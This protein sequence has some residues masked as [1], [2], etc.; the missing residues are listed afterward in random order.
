MKSQSLRWKSTILVPVPFSPPGGVY[1]NL[2]VAELG[3]GSIDGSLDGSLVGNVACAR[4]NLDAVLLGPLSSAGLEALDAASEENQVCAL[5][6]IA[7][8]HLL[9]QTRRSASDGND[10]T[11]EIEVCHWNHILSC[12]F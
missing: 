10:L 3:V 11:G 5:L 8:G 12:W 1:E 6:C 9:A 2:N 7:F 4:K